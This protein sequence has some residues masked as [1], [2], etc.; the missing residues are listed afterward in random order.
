MFF[1]AGSQVNR[2]NRV[3]WIDTREPWA[4]VAVELGT[5]TAMDV[6]TPTRLSGVPD[7]PGNRNLNLDPGLHPVPVI[8]NLQSTQF[9]NVNAQRT[10]RRPVSR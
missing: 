6:I 9:A 8:I 2:V 10:G 3:N 1:K 5:A 4:V 7:F